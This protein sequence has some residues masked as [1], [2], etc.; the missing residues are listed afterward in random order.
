MEV[1][2]GP[3]FRAAMTTRVLMEARRNVGGNLGEQ[4]LLGLY[5]DI[6]SLDPVMVPPPSAQRIAECVPLT[7][8]KDAHV[9]AGA[10]ECGAD[11]LLTLD[12]RHL[13]NPTVLSADLPVRVMTPG[14]FLD[15]VASQASR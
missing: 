14:D 5:R 8:A 6:A 10:L 7:T 11:Y 4:E 13:L 3:R 2:R 15:E 1:C 12:R 9:L